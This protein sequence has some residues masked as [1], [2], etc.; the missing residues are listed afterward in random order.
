MAF[1]AVRS[2]LETAARGDQLRRSSTAV[3][4]SGHSD[5]L[6]AAAGAGRSR[7]ARSKTATR[8]H[9]R[10][11]SLRSYWRY[12]PTDRHANRS[13]TPVGRT[14][15]RI[16][17]LACMR[18]RDREQV[19][20][21]MWQAIHACCDYRRASNSSLR[22]PHSKDKTRVQVISKALKRTPG[23]LR[24][25]ARVLG[26]P[27]GHRRTKKKRAWIFGGLTESRSYQRS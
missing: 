23:A 26:I 8:S 14:R 21:D 13:D 6:A 12:H 5:A 9:R 18:V 27:L 3:R 11:A 16:L 2:R 25:K 19:A 22:G 10:S 20:F 4:R 24:Q 7:S 15:S 1:P 17:D